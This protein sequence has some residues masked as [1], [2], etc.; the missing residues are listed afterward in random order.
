MTAWLDP[1]RRALD[2]APRPAAFFF[3]NDDVGREDSRLF[4]LLDL[5]EARALPVDLAVIPA[6]LD[7]DLA[8]CLAARGVA[9]RL[10]VHQHGWRHANHA[11]VG[12]KCE[13][14]P[15]RVPNAQ[16]ADLQSG[17]A[18]LEAAFGA[19]V[20][21][22]FTPPWNRCMQATVDLLAAGPWRVLSRDAG[23]TPLEA[24]T[25]VELPV[26]IDW[27]KEMARSADG[28]LLGQA[29]ADA[30]TTGRPVGI[31]LHHAVMTDDDHAALA[32]LLDLLAGHDRARCRTMMDCAFPG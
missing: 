6:A 8:R 17:R 24:G 19:L 4:P 20:D 10:R 11:R 26:T 22:I 30:T 32:A 9:G 16:A 13:F 29:T 28:A 23:A 1:L 12:R 2:A 3:R 25:L 14:G 15:E 21:P 7:D 31:M 18:R 27:Q 5:F